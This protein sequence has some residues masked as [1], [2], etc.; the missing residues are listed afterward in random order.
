MERESRCA[1]LHW[2]IAG[3][4]EVEFGRVRRLSVL[5]HKY[6]NQE[7]VLRTFH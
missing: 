1:A 4:Y 3:L 5:L 6:T 2:S 7:S